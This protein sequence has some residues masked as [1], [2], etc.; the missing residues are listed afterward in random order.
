M[1]AIPTSP[2]KTLPK[3][4]Y[5]L[6]VIVALSSLRVIDAQQITYANGIDA[7]TPTKNIYEYLDSSTGGKF[8]WNITLTEPLSIENITSSQGTFEMS[9][10]YKL[11]DQFYDISIYKNDCETLPE[12]TNPNNSDFSSFYSNY[13][14]RILG[15]DV[16]NIVNTVDSGS[17]VNDVEIKFLY[18]QDTVQDSNLW[19]ANKTG[20]NVE[21]CV[22]LRNYLNNP[23]D[24]TFTE[25][26]FLEVLYKIEVDSLTEFE[27]GIEITRLEATEGGVEQ[28]DYEETI[29]AFF[30]DDEFLTSPDGDARP[31]TQG[32]F[33]QICVRTRTGSAFGVHSIKDLNVYQIDGAGGSLGAT[34]PYVDNFIDSPLASTVCDTNNDN[35][36]DAVCYAK[37]QLLASYFTEDEPKSLQVN[38]TV[39]L[40]YVGR[41]RHLSVD[42]PVSLKVGNGDQGGVD[43]SL[44]AAAE[45]DGGN[46][47]SKTIELASS[48]EDSGTGT[49]TGTS[50]FTLGGIFST[51][52]AFLAGSSIFTL[53]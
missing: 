1:F 46:S 15:N 34:Y 44:Q 47:F 49:G 23:E 39:K 29:E 2:I 11:D 21:F 6:L 22:K 45:D 33:A 48:T 27:K 7:F 5:L 4:M 43:R 31:L 9:T 10:K 50:S 14:I 12:I 40:D 8:D 52:I 41:R 51:A 37:I 19:T 30:C 28:I 13:V 3:Y 53:A 38:G 17:G 32:D 20:G 35:T 42:V 25:I 18:D 36:T 26:H 24:S 16:N